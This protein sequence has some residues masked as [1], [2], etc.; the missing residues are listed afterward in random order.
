MKYCA[1]ISLLFSVASEVF[2]QTLP[3]LNVAPLSN[4][5]VVVSWPYTNAG[6]TFQEANAVASTNWQA[7][8]LV[9]VFDSNHATFSASMSAANAARFFRLKQ[10]AD[11]RG[12]YV[13]SEALPLSKNNSNALAAAFGVP[14]VDGLVL[15]LGWTNLETNLNQF[16]WGDL[17]TWMSN[18]V[19]AN[20]KVDL[21]LRAGNLTPAWLFAPR[22]N[23]GVGATPLTFSYSPQDGTTTNCQ[24]ETI[25]APWDTN[26]LAAWDSMLGAVSAHLKTKGSYE[27]VKLVRL[28]GINR[29][30]AELHLPSQTS[31][32]TGLDCVS[33]APAIWQAAGYTPS[34]LLSGW[35]NILA[36]FQTHFPDKSFS[37][38][39]IALTNNNPF[40][41]INDYGVITNVLGADQ[42]FP[43]LSL[44]SQMLRG[45]LVI[46]NNS[47]YPDR[48][49]MPQTVSSAQSL[50]TL[51]AFQ[52]N[53]QGPG[54][55]AD[56]NGTCSNAN[57][58]AML[59]TGIYPLQRT[60]SLRAQ[61]IEIF[62][63]DANAFT[64]AVWQAHSELFEGL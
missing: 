9:P 31:T 2:A 49:A 15:G 12:I 22:T 5:Q 54:S 1:A 32:N 42:N 11:L 38:A 51:I 27:A 10:P 40:P 35:S 41:P 28:T 58:L 30:T 37:V 61:Y 33:N 46:Q 18:A 50:G 43:L 6:F 29:N 24:V 19:A 16:A 8:A 55:S 3:R 26:F 59:E 25:A 47:L 14:G 20:L 62:P 36:S 57:Y 34:N 44:A 39:I 23:G 7:S 21:S 60:N 56:C 48:A 63:A 13:C 64:N 45:H 53:E 17:D 52:T 4:Q